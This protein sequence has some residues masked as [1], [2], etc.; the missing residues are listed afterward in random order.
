MN[1]SEKI[2]GNNVFQ[3]GM[4]TDS[5]IAFSDD[6]AYYYALNSVLETSEGDQGAISNEIGNL[7]CCDLKKDYKIIGHKLMTDD[8]FCLFSTNNI[9]SEIGI[10][11]SKLC[12]YT[13]VINDVCLD[14]NNCFPISA[15]FR[16]KNGCDRI[17]YFTDNRNVYRSIN[18]D[19]IKSYY[20]G[21]NLICSR[22][23]FSPDVKCGNIE[24]S[25]IKESGG[26]LLL[27]SYQFFIR[28]LDADLNSTN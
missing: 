22:L 9:S 24:V 19:D 28:Y 16:I 1:N 6:S 14:F 21:S 23:N 3:K 12:K 11:D 2:L 15:L 10:F 13:V 4:N 5:S 7:I 27:G 25:E 26:E 18:L 8:T 20:D 17:I